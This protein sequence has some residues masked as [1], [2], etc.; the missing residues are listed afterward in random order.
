M[1][2]PAIPAPQRRDLRMRVRLSDSAEQTVRA[3][4]RAHGLSVADYMRDRL[5]R[6]RIETRTRRRYDLATRQALRRIAVNLRQLIDL[7]AGI[8]EQSGV[9]ALHARLA[10]ILTR[11]QDFAAG[12]DE[13]GPATG[14]RVCAVR[15]SADQQTVIRALAAQCGLNVSDYARAM[16]I[17]GRVVCDQVEEIAP[18]NLA[19]LN[20]AG[21]A[22]NR[23]ARHAHVRLPRP[24]GLAA[25]VH[26][27]AARVDAL[28]EV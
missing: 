17:D 14:G 4:A 27:I 13:D 21:E 19:A 25:A 18:D 16:L 23:F 15:V 10:A 1:A 9:T 8:A 5:I 28:P 3:Q 6:G 22:L 11:E 12:L 7:D 26:E 2:R 24:L 20:A